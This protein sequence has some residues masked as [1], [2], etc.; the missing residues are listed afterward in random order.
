[1]NAQVKGLVLLVASSPDKLS[2]GLAADQA[3]SLPTDS[4]Q[5]ET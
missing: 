4:K 2:C 3:V 1:M 5:R